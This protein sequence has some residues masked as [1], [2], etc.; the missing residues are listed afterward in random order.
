MRNSRLF[1]RRFPALGAIALLV[2]IGALA[3]PTPA[4]AQSQ[5]PAPGKVTIAW[6]DWYSFDP[7]NTQ[8]Q[9]PKSVTV[10]WDRVQGA[11]GG[12]DVEYTI[13]PNMGWTQAG[14]VKDPKITIEGVTT[15]L[16]YIARV[17]G[18]GS[19]GPGAWGESNLITPHCPVGY[20]CMT[21]T[22]P[23]PVSDSAPTP[24]SASTPAP[25]SALTSNSASTPAPASVP[26][27]A[28]S[29]PATDVGHGA[30]SIVQLPAA[31][32]DIQVARADNALSVS[33]TQCDVTQASCN[34]GSPVT[35]YHVNLRSG[36]G[37]WARAKTLT[38]YTS[39]SDVEITGGVTNAAYVV[40]VGV[41]N[42]NATNWMSVSV[43]ALP[44]NVGNLD[45][46]S[47]S[48]GSA[49]SGQRWA[50]T[51]TTGSNPGGYMLKGVTA[52]MRAMNPNG[53]LRL[54]VH[55]ARG[56]NPSPTAKTTLT[57]ANPSAKE[58]TDAAY[59][60]EGDGCALSP[61]M[62]YF[63]VATASG[64]GY[65]WRYAYS[66]E[67]T[68]FPAGGG[69]AIGWGYYSDDGGATWDTWQDWQMFSVEFVERPS[70]VSLTASGVT[71]TTAT[72]TLTRYPGAW[73]LSDE[74][75][76]DTCK[77]ATGVTE[78]LTD[79]ERGESYVYKAYSDPNCANEI[80]SRR[81]TTLPS[82]L[83]ASDVGI[84]S[85]T[86]TIDGHAGEWY[87]KQTGP[88]EGAGMC[89]AATSGD[90]HT[91]DGLTPGAVYNV[92]AYSDD[93]CSRLIAAEKFYTMLYGPWNF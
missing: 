51:F 42:G 48:R 33:W 24:N 37:A 30:I 31:A 90:T 66:D 15:R 41:R 38:D 54:S 63:V 87:F 77:A 25:T 4:E 20:A 10:S 18:W 74:T 86:L 16:G 64:G 60:C 46:D 36:D 70:P 59:A 26:T 57:G 8:A 11:F 12:Y 69:W 17:R 5:L 71:D 84:S 52:L 29:T 62:T 68:S 73:W 93:S 56:D 67:Q 61:N 19:D 40:S 75:T 81:F 47:A 49:I 44:S 1:L 21:D 89:S 78:K 50:G 22:T 76:N 14:R 92:Q 85:A 39:G 32:S 28:P 55:A 2:L 79:L 65:E 23:A 88:G 58:W 83:D 35:G 53:D 82:S 80:T 9:M 6:S 43:P 34:G 45:S 91:L 27:S 3:L 13:D 7:K 72:L